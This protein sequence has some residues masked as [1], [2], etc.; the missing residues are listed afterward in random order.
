MVSIGSRHI[1]IT[2]LGTGEFNWSGVLVTGPSKF[3]KVFLRASLMVLRWSSDWL[4]ES[5]DKGFAGF[6]W[7]I[8][9]AA[10]SG[11]CSYTFMM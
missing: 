10:S 11:I 2:P 9:V 6:N 3:G 8:Y 1:R 7:L 5:V 4:T